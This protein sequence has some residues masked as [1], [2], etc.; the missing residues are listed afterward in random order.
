[1]SKSDARMEGSTRKMQ[2]WETNINIEKHQA[3]P[4]PKQTRQHGRPRTGL[5]AV[6]MASECH[7]ATGTF[8]T[9]TLPRRG[10]LSYK[11]FDHDGSVVRLQYDPR[12]YPLPPATDKTNGKRER[13]REPGEE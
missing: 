10:G 5:D 9:G 7:N 3:N 11:H 4:N 2:D 6:G 12:P 8:A 13:K 1:M